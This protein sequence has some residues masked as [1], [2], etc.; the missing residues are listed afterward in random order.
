MGISIPDEFRPDLAMVGEWQVTSEH[1]I[2]TDEEKRT[3]AIALGVRKREVEDAEETTQLTKKRWGPAYRNDPFDEDNG[4]LD[5]LLSNA[6]S[7][8]KEASRG[9]AVKE[10]VKVE[11]NVSGTVNSGQAVPTQAAGTTGYVT[12]KHADRAM[13]PQAA[14]TVEFAAIKQESHEEHDMPRDIPPIEAIGKQEGDLGSTGIVFKKRKAKNI[15]Q[16]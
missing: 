7:K 8:G 13:P 14:G 11:F 12:I 2:E 3:E 15:R 9:S 6:T 4:D 16:K 1:V 5:V 10:E